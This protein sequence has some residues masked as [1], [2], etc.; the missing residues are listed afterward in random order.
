M[1]RNRLTE[2]WGGF[3]LP[4]KAFPHGE[5]G[6]CVPRKHETDEGVIFPFSR[7][8]RHFTRAGA[9]GDIDG[10]RKYRGIVPGGNPWKGL[11]QSAPN[12]DMTATGSH[13]YFRFAARS[14]FPPRGRLRVLSGGQAA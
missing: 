5:G 12:Y 6:S 1:I 11:Y 2:G 4:P 14:T 8:H 13:Y 10:S 9:K 7:F 3:L